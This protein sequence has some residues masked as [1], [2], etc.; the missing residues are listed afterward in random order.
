M[1]WILSFFALL[2]FSFA[3]VFY[4]LF[5]KNGGRPL[6]EGLEG[7]PM[8]SLLF[9]RD[10]MLRHLKEV[11]IEGSL[12]R[13]IAEQKE[14]LQSELASILL[15]IDKMKEKLKGKKTKKADSKTDSSNKAWAVSTM[16]IVLVSS[17]G[18]YLVMGTPKA[19]PPTKP[20]ASTNNVDINAM[21]EG[22][23]QRL[24]NEPQ[25]REGWIRLARSFGVMGQFTRA[26]EAY[27]HLLTL[28]PD[29]IDFSVSLAEMQVRS[30]DIN[31][32]E[33]GMVR[34]Y[35]ILEKHPNRPEALWFLGAL[36]MQEGK[37][38]QALTMWQ[39]LLDQLQPGTSNYD[40]VLSAI[41]Q[42]KSGEN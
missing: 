14:Q 12:D 7:D 38:Q 10:V 11:N 20:P 13:D 6:P 41:N 35:D 31:L 24:E 26:V 18:L 32:L 1:T 23:A 21:V 9:E 15:R 36:S 40:N 3:G 22:L 39:K 4:P 28:E 27:T 37:T 17:A 5:N 25:N 42:A 34:F 19:V 8:A 2:L 29:N 33:K 16:L 30:G